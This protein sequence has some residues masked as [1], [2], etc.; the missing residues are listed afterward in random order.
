MAQ[1]FISHIEEEQNVAEAIA[2]A[3]EAA[4]YSVWYYERDSYPG[5]DYLDQVA[6]AIE[7]C[8]AVLVVIS[9]DSIASHQVE[10]EVKWS[11][12]LRKNFVPVL[13]RMTWSDFQQRRSPWRM[14]LGIAAGVAIQGKDVIS[15]IPRIIKGL[16]N[17]GV[18][19]VGLQSGITEQRDEQDFQPAR[20]MSNERLQVSNVVRERTTSSKS[21]PRN[22]RRYCTLEGH[23]SY[24]VQVAV[25]ADGRYMASSSW[26]HTLKLWDISDRKE[27]RTLGG[28][29][30]AVWAL[31][32][33]PDARHALSGS[34]DGT[35]RVWD[36]ETGREERTLSGHSEGVYGVAFVASAYYVSVGIDN[37]AILWSA[38]TGKEEDRCEVPQDECYGLYCVAVTQE[39]PV[40]VLYGGGVGGGKVRIWSIR[41]G[42]DLPTLQGHRDKVNHVAVTR[43]GRLC[44][45]A[46]SDKTL[47]IWDLTKFCQLRSLIGHSGEVLGVALSPDE[48]LVI[49]SSMDGTLKAWETA[50]GR[51][52][53]TFN[54]D[55]AIYSC[56]F[57]PD[58][59]TIAFGA[60]DNAIHLLRLE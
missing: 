44:V 38:E 29:T 54:G 7:T 3:L 58:G 9:P 43:D 8:Q 19:P 32:L 22:V 1:V 37:N 17:L 23:S 47:K 4:G 41:N 21:F 52:L 48:R 5:A 10:D 45:T 50:T 30:D 14:A 15:V 46:S 11:R 26:D 34:D 60:A 57:F 28:H 35:V 13:H 42:E 6:N 20:D 59:E 40:W 18:K 27:L 36:L 12:E 53:A 51:E 16:E 56:A 33:S 31:A 49:S 2:G 24:V 25:S 55:A 39:E